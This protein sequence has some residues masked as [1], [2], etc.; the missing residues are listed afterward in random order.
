MAKSIC[1]GCGRIFKS[2]SAFS[3]HRTG[4][5]DIYP[6]MPGF[7]ELS[8]EIQAQQRHC[9]TDE[10][11]FKIQFEYDSEHQW[12]TDRSDVISPER[13]KILDEKTRQKKIARESL[14]TSEDDRQEWH[15]APEDDM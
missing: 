4:E 12:W 6:R 8:P 1:S 2:A 9:M 10:E 3:K 14:H 7:S 15:N 5:F 11:M 13:K